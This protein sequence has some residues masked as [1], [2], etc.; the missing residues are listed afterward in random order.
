MQNP[1]LA[2]QGVDEAD[3]ELRILRCDVIIKSHQSHT[4]PRMGY[5]A[6]YASFKIKPRNFPGN[7]V[8]I[9][10]HTQLENR[11]GNSQLAGWK[12]KLNRDVR[13][14]ELELNIFSKVFNEHGFE[15]P[16]IRGST[17]E[18]KVLSGKDFEKV[19]KGLE[20]ITLFKLYQRC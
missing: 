1:Y 19:I 4:V 5:P 15:C 20:V 8:V 14:I 10:S 17:K 13:T 11:K 12:E 18:E 7:A 16:Q 3:I 2:M 6:A 9:V